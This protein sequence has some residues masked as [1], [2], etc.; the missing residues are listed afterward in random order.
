MTAPE[1]RNGSTRWICSGTVEK[2]SLVILGQEG[3][4]AVVLVL[5]RAPVHLGG[6][7]C[8]HN[9]HMLHAGPSIKL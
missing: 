9:L 1:M 2:D 6:V 5:Q 7:G 8:Q 4:D 3:D